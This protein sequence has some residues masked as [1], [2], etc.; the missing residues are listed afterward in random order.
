MA[1]LLGNNEVDMT[2]GSILKQILGFALPMIIGL[3]FQQLYNTADMIIVGQFAGKQALAAVGGTTTIINTLVGFCSGLATGAGVVVSQYFGRHDKE[4]LSKAVHSSIA[5]CLVLCGASTV[6]GVLLAKPMLLLMN[7]PS[8]V[9]K[10][11]TEYLAIYFAGVSGLLLYNTLT[12]IMRAVGDSTRPVVFLLISSVINIGLDLLFVAVFNMGAFGAG[13]AT[14]ISQFISAIM[15]L[16]VLVKTNADYKVELKK[17]RWDKGMIAEIWRIGF[18]G[19]LQMAI[20]SF[21]NTFVHSYTNVYGTDAMTGYSVHMKLDSFI[22]VVTQAFSLAT[23]TFV[24]Q[25]YGAGR[26][27]RA[28]KGVSI[29]LIFSIIVCVVL[30]ALFII[31][32]PQLSSLFNSDEGVINMTVFFT[33]VTVPFYFVSCFNQNYAGALRGAGR[34]KTPM[35]ILLATFVG[36]RQLYLFAVSKIFVGSL[37][38]VTLCIP[39]AWIVCGIIMG[40]AYYSSPMLKDAKN[41][42][43][44]NAQDPYYQIEE[45]QKS[46]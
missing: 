13:L 10:P 17:I 39:I 22:M 26:Y 8:D 24:G 23:T 2:N 44:L 35:F 19:G 18:P 3:L 30:S 16:I 20:T 43:P 28:S 41:E 6:L 31:F 21:S 46:I 14:I 33:R 25:N 1:K 32:A 27:K 7:T 12:G 45:N 37:L 38:A 9:I 40:I 11:A 34:S 4:G 29:S 5:L 15:A 42:V 36:F